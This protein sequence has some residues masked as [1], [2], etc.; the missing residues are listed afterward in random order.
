MVVLV[1]WAV[2]VAP[3]V[4]VR[5]A[6]VAVRVWWVSLAVLA[7]RAAPVVRR[8][9]VAVVSRVRAVVVVMAVPGVWVARVTWAAAAART[10]TAMPVGLV[11]PAVPAGPR[12]SVERGR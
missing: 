8:G 9:R 10:Q 5:R 3:V 1:V 2:R 4:V 12:V 7:V 11:A 6:R